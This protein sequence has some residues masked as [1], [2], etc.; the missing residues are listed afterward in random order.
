[1]H[2]GAGDRPLPM[3]SH[4]FT[5]KP[6]SFPR[7]TTRVVHYTTLTA[8]SVDLRAAISSQRLERSSYPSLRRYRYRALPCHLLP[9][10]CA[11]SMLIA[12][13][14][15]DRFRVEPNLGRLRAFAGSLTKLGGSPARRGP[16]YV[17]DTFPSDFQNR[18]ED[19]ADAVSMAGPEVENMRS[20]LI[21][22][23]VECANMGCRK[24]GDVDIIADA[25]AI[26]RRII[27]AEKVNGG[28]SP[29]IALMARE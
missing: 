20:F 26:R 6:T 16:K 19:L 10:H 8:Y 14:S 5:V 3:T 2:S 7:W 11:S 15:G 13:L 23:P 12:R 29:V 27:R 17:G 18:F 25:C 9:R 4:L 24:V 28:R 1:M 21:D 22:N